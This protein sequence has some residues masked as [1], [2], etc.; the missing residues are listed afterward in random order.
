MPKNSFRIAIVI[1]ALVSI[2]LIVM[3]V[4]NDKK[5]FRANVS[6][7]LIEVW[8]SHSSQMEQSKR[9]VCNS[10]APLLLA[11]ANKS[12]LVI[13]SVTVSFAARRSGQ[14]D[15]LVASDDADFTYNY[16][17]LPDTFQATCAEAPRVTETWDSASL[18]WSVSVST[19][20]PPTY[21]SFEEWMAEEAASSE[22]DAFGE[23]K[24]RYGRQKVIENVFDQFDTGY[25]E[26]ITVPS[27]PEAWRFGYPE[28]PI[29]LNHPR[30]NY[31]VNKAKN[32]VLGLDQSGKWQLIPSAVNE[33]G[34][35]LIF[36][37]TDWKHLDHP[38]PW[39]NYERPRVTIEMP[40]E[41]K[42][43]FH[44]DLSVSTIKDALRPRF[45]GENLSDDE[46][47]ELLDLSVRKACSDDDVNLCASE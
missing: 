24:E 42:F 43:E 35:V 11:I 23:M 6:D 8:V 15:N 38:G 2:A 7:E 27:K 33:D 14:L 20:D 4:V 9:S 10:R 37:D 13:K 19:N 34:T 26:R 5:W 21:V 30:A 17:I 36:E 3:W 44:S 12:D 47:Q 16:F 25:S 22:I 46:W 32:I 45:V 29:H 40:D 31:A 28:V 39:L 41:T 18:I 1:T